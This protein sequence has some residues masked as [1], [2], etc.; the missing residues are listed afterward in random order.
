MKNNKTKLIEA[1]VHRC[2]SQM[3]FKIGARKNLTNQTGEPQVIRPATKLK[4]DSKTGA[5]P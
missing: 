2:R 5:P 4:R 3:F 1:V